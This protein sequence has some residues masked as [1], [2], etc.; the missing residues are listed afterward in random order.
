MPRPLLREWALC[1]GR[2]QAQRKWPMESGPG[3]VHD[4]W[5]QPLS[6]G[7]SSV[8][9]AWARQAVV[10][11]G[12]QGQES[13]HALEV[14]GDPVTSWVTLVLLWR[15]FWWPWVPHGPPWALPKPAR[16]D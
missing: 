4:L 7:I 9:P 8:T 12:G 14:A 15:H 10:E 16:G 6:K 3:A 13:I 2:R 5:A 1:L 11:E